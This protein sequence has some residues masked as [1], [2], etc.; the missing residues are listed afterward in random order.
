MRSKTLKTML[1]DLGISEEEEVKE[2]LPLPTIVSK[3]LERVMTWCEHHQDDPEDVENTEPDVNP[4][5]TRNVRKIYDL[6]PWDM[7]WMLPMQKDLDLLMD[8]V[9]AANYLY[10]PKLIEITCMTIAKML[11]D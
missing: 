6:P 7:N 2:I 9:K 1:E 8:V 5:G 10:I 3:A 11:K 4:D